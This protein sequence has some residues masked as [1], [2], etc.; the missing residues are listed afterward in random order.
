MTALAVPFRQLVE[1]RLWPLALLLLVALAAVPM[2]LAK[3]PGGALPTPVASAANATASAGATEPIVSVSEPAAREKGRRVLGSKKNPFKPAVKAK[4]ADETVTVAPDAAP[5]TGS[6]GGGSGVTLPG[7]TLPLAPKKTYE[8]YS[9][10]VRFGET[11]VEKL[12]TRNLK[13]LTSLPNVAQPVVIYLGLKSDLKTAVFLV[14]ASATVQGDGKCVPDPANCQTLELE[15]GETAFLDVANTDGAGT[16]G[17]QYQLDFVKVKR[18]K[19]TDAKVAARSRAA[20]SSGG[21]QALRA[22]SSRVGGY[23]YDP[24]TGTVRKFSAKQLKAEA[25]ARAA[26]VD[27]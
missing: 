16:A 18:K 19:T 20:E 22:R 23:R 14:D 17:R 8:L 9:L 3:D 6:A 4:K 26:R 10:T 24:K 27:D 1:R 5:K 21:R 7:T 25:A 15:V 12:G 13:R 2:M 11:T